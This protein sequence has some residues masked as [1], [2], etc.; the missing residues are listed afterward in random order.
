MLTLDYH[1]SSVISCCGLQTRGN[2]NTMWHSINHT[3]P[4][5][6]TQGIPLCQQRSSPCGWETKRFHSWHFWEASCFSASL[7]QFWRSELIFYHRNLKGEPQDGI[8]LPYL[9]HCS[10]HNAVLEETQTITPFSF[11]TFTSNLTECG[12]DIYRQSISGGIVSL[13]PYCSLPISSSVHEYSCVKFE[14]GVVLIQIVL[15]FFFFF[16]Y[17][18]SSRH[19]KSLDFGSQCCYL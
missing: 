13:S 14:K 15:T 7:D 11:T 3:C 6:E 16:L 2:M 19:I 17:P 9:F 10:E 12:N 4:S 1:L 18:I 8:C 5:G